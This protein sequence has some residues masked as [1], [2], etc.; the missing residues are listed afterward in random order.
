MVFPESTLNNLQSAVDIPRQEARIIPCNN[1]TYNPNIQHI[2]CAAQR[3]RQ[4]I[5]VNLVMRRNCTLEA[6]EN[7]DDRPCAG[8]WNLYST[9]VVFDTN[10]MVIST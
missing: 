8:D 3:N 1:D 10:G 5:V 6:I 2:S 7:N 9:N 4:Y